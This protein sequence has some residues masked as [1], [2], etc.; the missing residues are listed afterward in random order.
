MQELKALIDTIQKQLGDYSCKH[1][2][3]E[4]FQIYNKEASR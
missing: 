1:D 3:R 2:I 4:A